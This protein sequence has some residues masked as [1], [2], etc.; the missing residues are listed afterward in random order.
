[1]ADIVQREHIDGGA[2]LGRVV[3]F[4]CGSGVRHLLLGGLRNDLHGPVAA[5]G[6]LSVFREGGKIEPGLGVRRC[7]KFGRLSREALWA[8]API[9]PEVRREWANCSVR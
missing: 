1:M 7:D 2:L 8:E 6:R 9:R 3:L 5:M 4:H